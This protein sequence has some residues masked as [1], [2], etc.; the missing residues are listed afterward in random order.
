MK[1]V[2]IISTSLRRN[3]NSDYIAREFERG[4]KDAGNEVEFIS[5]IGKKI[6][7]CIGCLSC[8][9]TQECVIKDDANEIAEKVKN[10]DVVVYATPVY[11]YEMS[12]Q[13]KTLID[14]MNCL[15][16]SDYKFRDVYLLAASAEDE[17]SAMDGAVKGVQGWVD[18]FEKATLAGVIRGTGL[19]ET[20]EA[21]KDE[22]ILK[23]A[24]EMGKSV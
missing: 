2:L 21:K 13:M 5:L 14:R 22:E 18:C 8:Q 16:P 20:G 24:Y 11:Y 15:F 19:T 10:A 9:L 23:K 4:A 17:E 12:G 7:F 3:S 6:D 1:K